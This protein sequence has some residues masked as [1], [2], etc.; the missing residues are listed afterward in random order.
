M[1]RTPQLSQQKKRSL[2]QQYRPPAQ[3]PTHPPHQNQQQLHTTITAHAHRSQ[4]AQEERYRPPPLPQSQQ[5]QE[6]QQRQALQKQRNMPPLHAY[7]TNDL[8]DAR[9]QNGVAPEHGGPM[10]TANDEL[11]GMSDNDRRKHKESRGK[12]QDDINLN[13]LNLPVYERSESSF[14]WIVLILACWSMFG[15]YYCFDNPAALSNQFQDADGEYHLS[16]L[17]FNLLYSVYSIPNVIL[18][19]FGGVLVDK[20]GAEIRF[21]F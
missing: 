3:H 11:Y 9:G 4:Q 21:V 2:D 12:T 10:I 17:Q 5:F 15:S 18:P 8:F 16:S 20:I 19:L 1:T 14:R 6:Q 13:P 7:S